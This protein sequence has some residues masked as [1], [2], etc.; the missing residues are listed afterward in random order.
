MEIDRQQEI[1]I[2][3]VIGVESLPCSILGQKKIFTIKGEELT[4]NLLLPWN[5]PMT[6][7]EEQLVELVKG[8][9]SNGM[10]KVADLINPDEPDQI[11]KVKIDRI[12]QNQT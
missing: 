7:L 2:A 8:N 9:W 4:G 6:W 5:L 3:T 1:V 11:V 10:F 12:Q